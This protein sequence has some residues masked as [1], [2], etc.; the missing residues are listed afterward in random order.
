MV[1]LALSLLLLAAVIAMFGRVSEGIADSRSLLE[2]ADRLRLTAQR[3]QMDLAGVTVT[4]NPPA[5]PANNE[6]YFEYIEG[7]ATANSNIAI[8]SDTGQSDPTVG[9]YDDILMFTTRSSGKPF[10]GKLNGNPAQSYV[11]EVAWFIRGHTLHRRVLLVLPG[12][13]ARAAANDFYANNNG[14]DIS[15]HANLNA[16]GALDGTV[17]ANTLAD[18]TC[19]GC[20]FAHNRIC[21]P[22]GPSPCDWGQLG[23]PTLAE[24]SSTNWKVGGPV[25]LPAAKTNLDFWSNR[26]STSNTDSY[27]WADNTLQAGGSRLSDDIILTNVIGFDV[28]AWDPKANNGQGGQGMYVDLGYNTGLPNPTDFSSLGDNKSSL[29]A[30]NNNSARVYDTY[31]TA[32]FSSNGSNGIDDDNDGVVDNDNE[33]S[34]AGTALLPPYWC[35]LRGI[36][37]KIRTFEPDSKQIREVTVVQDFLPQ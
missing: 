2:M 30:A 15:V 27:P 3:L 7:A 23:L 11:A 8:N 9:D 10:V 14:N 25:S 17:T 26:T 18:L 33:K 22:A 1:A 28:K 13:V 37:V 34:P 35:P 29:M 19:R 32:Y 4:M 5:N 31:S 21:P 6:G 24:C 20:R 16:S 12:T 36:Q